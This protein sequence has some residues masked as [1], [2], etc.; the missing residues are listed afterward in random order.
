MDSRDSGTR[1][2]GLSWVGTPVANVSGYVQNQTRTIN[3]MLING[4]TINLSASTD[5][6]VE[7]GS[8]LDVDGGYIHYLGG[9]IGTTRL[10]GADGHLYDAADADPNVT[11]IGIAGQFTINH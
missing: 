1:D 10:T 3:D 2:D 9:M 11:Y 4:G 5:L 7:H 6:I 8:L